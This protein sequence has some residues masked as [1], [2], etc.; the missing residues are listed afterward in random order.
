METRSDAV[1]LFVCLFYVKRTKLKKR[2]ALM[3]GILFGQVLNC[4][5]RCYV[6]GPWEAT[7]VLHE[8]SY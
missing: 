1:S 7:D 3:F 4:D 2:N 5:S 6:Y 8:D